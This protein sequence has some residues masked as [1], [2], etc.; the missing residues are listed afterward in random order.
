M[1]SKARKPDG[2]LLGTLVALL[3]YGF[4]VFVS[5]ALGLLARD[6]QES[7]FSVV[8]SQAIGLIIGTA[9][10]YVAY[11]IPLEVWRR[12]S[13]FIYG[14]GLILLALVLVPGIGLS[15]N[16]ARRWLSIGPLTIQPVEFMK[17][18]YMLLLASW[19]MARRKSLESFKTGMGPYV[20]ITALP[21]ILL[22]LQPDN[23]SIAVMGATGLAMAFAL[24]AR[25]KHVM[26]VCGI[27]LLVGLSAYAAFPS[28]RERVHTFIS[29]SADARGS[30]YQV[31]QSLIA[32]GS[33]EF[34]GRGFGQSAQKFH[35]LP[36]PIND[37]IF[38]V[39]AEEFG[40]VG[41]SILIALLAMLGLRGFTIATKAA[42][43][44][45]C[46]LAVGI[47]SYLT[48]QAFMNIASM[49]GIIPLSGLP[50]PFVSHGGSSLMASLFLMGILLSVSAGRGKDA[51]V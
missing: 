13:P 48:L 8:R 17:I 28:V 23:D 45:G 6:G 16:G 15:F 43:P 1:R 37:S 2:I 46:A 49:L 29:P 40:F 14:G 7:F 36:E 11:R 44:Y 34:W 41:A 30:G 47:S 9:A 35:H 31:Q 39:A 50:L 20:V 4:F 42:T 12:F 33:G 24:G 18:G 38:A 5:A 21:A 25:I 10:L 3:A 27:G 22:I 26:I 32:I 19:L 51:M